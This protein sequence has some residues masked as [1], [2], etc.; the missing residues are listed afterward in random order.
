MKIN[1][2]LVLF[3][4][5]DEK[6]YSYTRS[7]STLRRLLCLHGSVVYLVRAGHTQQTVCDPCWSLSFAALVAVNR[8]PISPLFLDVSHSLTTYLYGWISIIANPTMII[9]AG[10]A[11]QLV[12]IG[13]ENVGIHRRFRCIALFAIQQNPLFPSLLHVNHALAT[14]LH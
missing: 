1:D 12:A 3:F 10:N 5:V 9:I 6:W 4:T 11:Q 14:Y 7:H 2:I 8:D 13:V